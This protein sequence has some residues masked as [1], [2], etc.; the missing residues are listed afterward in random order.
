VLAEHGGA[1]TT[2]TTT[3]IAAS[4]TILD[5]LRLQKIS[6][7]RK[8]HNVYLTDVNIK[9]L[10]LPTNCKQKQKQKASTKRYQERATTTQESFAEE[11]ESLEC[12]AF[13]HVR[14]RS[15]AAAATTTTTASRIIILHRNL[16]DLLPS[17][18]KQKILILSCERKKEKASLKDINRKL[19]N[20][21][22]NCEE[23][24]KRRKKSFD[25]M[26][27]RRKSCLQEEKASQRGA[28]E[29]RSC[30]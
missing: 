13:D 7:Q 11:R 30:V 23:K 28:R 16:Q 20:L 15:A 3:A 2:T 19:Q 29:K 5:D 17:R 22:K 4:S 14:G 25:K 24:K 1:K 26:L 9:L 10:K 8:K 21:S 27:P 6:C 18:Q 12:A